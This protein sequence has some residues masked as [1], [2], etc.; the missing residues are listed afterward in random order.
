MLER[1]DVCVCGGGP[2]GFIAAIAAARSGAKT[3][4]LEKLGFPGG[5]ATAGLVGPISKFNFKGRR[6][7][8]GLPVEFIERLAAANGAIIDLPSGNVPFDS[9]IYK[10]VALETLKEAGVEILFHATLY[11]AEFSKNNLLSKALVCSEGAR[12]GVE[13]RRFVDCSG[14]GSLIATRPDLWRKRNVPEANQPLSL[15]FKLSGV[16]T[17]KLTLLMAEDGVKYANQTLR[18]ALEESM[19]EGEISNFGGPWAL[20]GSVITEGQVSV[21]CLRYSGDAC[22]PRDFSRAETRTRSELL[23]IV[24]I[25]RRADPAFASCRVL[26]TA[27][28]VGIRESRELVAEY[29]LSA[30]DVFSSRH[31]HDSVACGAH[32]VDRHLP[33]GNGQKVEFLKY[34]YEI[35][36]RC[37]VSAKCPNLMAAGALVSAEPTAF[38]T[39]RVQAQCMAMGQAVGTAAA[40]SARDEVSVNDIQDSVLRE[41]LLASGAIIKHESGML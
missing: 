18:A 7:V 8:G 41:A 27:V 33:S 12:I 20:W 5:L 9:E 25:F 36:F 11:G 30:D 15:V 34:P 21:N 38:A 23:K 17:S 35:P 19:A 16:D 6:V 28:T 14:S 22:D 3:I 1:F 24:E 4:L 26:E 37:L 32:P 40:I 31:F 10:Q 39:A 13:A 2:S 29:R